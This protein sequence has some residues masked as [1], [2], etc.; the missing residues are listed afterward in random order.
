MTVT[1]PGAPRRRGTAGRRT[2]RPLHPVAWWAWAIALAVTASQTTNP[3]LLLLIVVVT[4]VVIVH[5]RSDA[6]WSRAYKYYLAV[7]LTVV[8]VRVVFRSVFGG[9]DAAAT[10][11]L[12]RLPQVPL[13]SWAAGIQLGGPVTLDGTLS[14]CYDGVRLATLL[15][16]LGAANV[17]ANPKRMLRVLPGA[18]FELG[19]ATTVAFTVAPQMVESLHR[20]RRAR[21]LRGGGGRGPGALRAIVVPVVED[22][23][24]RSLRLA[25]AMDARGYGRH[26]AMSLR[27][28][29]STGALMLAGLSALCVGV[30]GVLDASMPRALGIPM[31][32]VG[33]ALCLAGLALGGRRVRR[34]TY[35]P[36][37]WR[38]PEWL[39]LASGA[40][41]AVV[42]TLGLGLSPAGLNPST[43]PPVWP[44]FPVA[45]VLAI[46]TAL[47]PALA[48]P[49]P[50]RS[51]APRGNLVSPGNVLPETDGAR[52]EATPV[53]ASAGRS[54]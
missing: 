19:V 28:R 51:R 11:V 39:V 27:V 29:R 32:A 35:R 40:V 20:V 5:R 1:R 31:L 34:S 36:D 21:R 33:S 54:A 30:Y 45:A 16:C 43:Q 48:A 37:P 46:A 24:E 53:R 14:A 3:L 44:S 2:P 13:P 18:L 49:P 6:P 38:L 52:P 17:L 8:A 15:C 22:A 23:L 7:A 4:G 25:A 26:G 50:V 42:L 41:P 12:F 47:L 9:D 10:H